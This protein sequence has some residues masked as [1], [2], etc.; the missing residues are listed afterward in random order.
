M[1]MVVGKSFT[2]WGGEDKY[3]DSCFLV[4]Q[5]NLASFGSGVILAVDQ[6]IF[7]YIAG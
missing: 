1:G 2:K 4:W 7:I 6:R 5:N 3:E